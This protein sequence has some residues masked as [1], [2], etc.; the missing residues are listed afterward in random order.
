[1]LL[2]EV[3]YKSND[4]GMCQPKNNQLHESDEISTGIATSSGMG[5]YQDTRLGYTHIYPNSTYNNLNTD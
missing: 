2:K 4:S 1:M 3:T 5:W